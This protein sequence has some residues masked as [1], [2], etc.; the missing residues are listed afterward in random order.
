M[1][2]DFYHQTVTTQQVEEYMAQHTGL[3]LKAF[4]N[5]YLRDI[6]IPVLEYQIK[7]KKLSY[8]YTNIVDGLTMPV[9]IT[10]DNAEKVKITPTV[11]WQEITHTSNIRMISVDPSVYIEKNMVEKKK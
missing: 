10:I 5:Q 6:R 8:R 1:Q 2:K 9:H 3:E 11:N 7:D 4:F